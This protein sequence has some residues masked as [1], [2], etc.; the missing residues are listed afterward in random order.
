MTL[1]GRDSLL[2]AWMTPA[3]R[4][5]LA[6]GRPASAGRSSRARDDDPS[7]RSSRARSSTNCVAMAA[8]A[9]S[10]PA[11]VL[12]HRRRHAAVRHA[13]AEAWRWGAL[14][15][16]RS[17]LAPAVGRRSTGSSATA[18]PTAM[19]SSTTAAATTA[20]SPTKG[21]RTPGTGSRPPT[22]P[23]PTGPIALVEVQGYAYAA[24]QGAAE[25]ADA[26][27][28]GSSRHDLAAHAEALQGP[29]QRHVLGCPRLVRAG[30]DGG[31]RH[32]DSLT[33]NPGHALWRGSPTTTTPIATSIASWNRTCGPAGASGPWRP[34][35]RRTTPSATTTARSGRMTRP[36]APRARPAT[37][38]GTSSIRSSRRPRCAAR[39]RRPPARAVRRE[40]LATT[41]PMPVAYPSSCSPQAWASASVLLL[42]RTMLDCHRRRTVWRR[43]GPPSTSTTASASTGCGP[44]DDCTISRVVDGHAD[45]AS[46]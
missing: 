39:L 22:G 3:V 24:L 23:L 2:T 42:V 5:P 18:I 41:L 19:G 15:A 13:A 45:W 11:A 21:G 32:V 29:V 8:A 38:G 20:G 26:D 9:R 17:A 30:L 27:G 25:L 44:T 35:W 28:S 31:G 14:D 46:G 4:R 34:P 10:R 16:T 43:R 1:F 36:S 37:A 7:P 33:T 6:A 40:S 12:R